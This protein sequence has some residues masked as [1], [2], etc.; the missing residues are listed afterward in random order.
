LLGAAQERQLQL[1]R[2]AR[3]AYVMRNRGFTLI[4]LMV[5]LVIVAIILL[6]GTPHYAEFMDNTRVRNATESF[7]NGVRQAQLAAVRR[8]E[9][10]KFVLTGSG[11][12]VRDVESDGLLDTEPVHELTAATA[13]KVVVEPA[14]A[15]EITF[16]GLGRA[17]AKNPPDDTEPIV[18][19]KVS[20][21]GA[22]TRPLGVALGVPGGSVKVC[23]PDSK[24][25][26]AG[27][28]DPIACPYPW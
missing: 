20:P 17:L 28:K 21:A 18:R 19:V 9:P 7:A 24:F 6:L 11:W 27:S 25:T 4:E 12:E 2:I 22:G 5:G 16:N 26:N 8:N 3:Q 1:T 14:G 13:P 23:D 10:V 15:N